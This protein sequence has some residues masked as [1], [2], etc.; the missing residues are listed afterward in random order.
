V[1]FE[2]DCGRSSVFSSDVGARIYHS[3]CQDSAAR[4]ERSHPP[5]GFFFGRRDYSSVLE[6]K[7]RFFLRA[8][9]GYFTEVVLVN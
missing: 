8:A 3:S 4:F 7:L 1:D 5:I 6:S 2:G 9:F